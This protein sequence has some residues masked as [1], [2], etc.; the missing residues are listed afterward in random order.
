MVYAAAEIG[1]N[2]VMLRAAGEVREGWKEREW[3][4]RE[5]RVEDSYGI[6]CAHMSLYIVAFV[7]YTHLTLYHICFI[8]LLL[9]ERPF[10][11]LE[12]F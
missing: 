6:L 10:R 7:V 2:G 3:E 11:M 9:N 12:V 1:M 8:V 5:K 4:Q